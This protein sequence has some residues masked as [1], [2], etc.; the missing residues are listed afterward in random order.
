M[1]CRDL[2]L[3]PMHMGHGAVHVLATL[4]FEGGEGQSL[5]VNDARTS[6]LCLMYTVL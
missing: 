4:S 5:G 6:V 1:G 2:L 3:C